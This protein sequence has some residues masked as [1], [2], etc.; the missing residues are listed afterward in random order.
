MLSKNAVII[1]LYNI[2]V[3]FWIKEQLKIEFQNSP[4]GLKMEDTMSKVDQYESK[5]FTYWR[6]E[7]RRRVK[8]WSIQNLK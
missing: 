4:Y 1:V 8:I 3:W 7:E 6:A 5:K 2:M